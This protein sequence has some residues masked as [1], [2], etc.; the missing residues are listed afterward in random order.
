MRQAIEREQGG[1]GGEP[2]VDPLLV[3]V[4]DEMAGEEGDLLCIG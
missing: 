1:C 3:S 4:Q 2:E